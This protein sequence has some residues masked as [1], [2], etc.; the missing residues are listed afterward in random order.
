MNIIFK[1]NQFNHGDMST[2]IVGNI[3]QLGAWDPNKS[4]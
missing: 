2:C 1:I 3:P 4:I